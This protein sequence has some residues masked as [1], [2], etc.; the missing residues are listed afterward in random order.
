MDFDYSQIN[1][2][3][4]FG[5]LSENEVK[6]LF[7]CLK[8]IVKSYKKGGLIIGEGDSAKNVGI[9][10]YGEVMLVKEDY[11]GNRSIMSTVESPN[12]FG[13]SFACSE[14]DEMPLSVTASSDCAV[15]FI[16]RERINTMCSKSCE[17]HKKLIYNLL[18]IV[19][20]KN[21]E[22][23]EKLE[24]LS[25]RSTREKLLAYLHSCAASA[26]S[27]S[28]T[29]PFNRQELADFLCVERSALSAVI[30]GL[31]KEN[32]IKADKNKFTVIR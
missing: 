16:S 3:S 8:P 31:R 10:L 21:I 14:A 23:S 20:Q 15:M 29:I 30:S 24:F 25:K 11:F 13:E 6:R 9:V 27:S 28:F 7:L 17:L 5:G 32:I 18:G 26:E 2:V 12:L 1:S 4:L 19:A 22:L